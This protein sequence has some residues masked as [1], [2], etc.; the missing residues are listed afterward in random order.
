M[1]TFSKLGQMGRLGNS[2]FQIAATIGQARKCKA[3][4]LLPK[5]GYSAS[6]KGPFS[7]GEVVRGW[8]S[9]PEPYF[10]Y[11]EMICLGDIDLQGYFQSVK[12]FA[13]CED[14]IREIFSPSK[15]VETYVSS[16][17]ATGSIP[18]ERIGVHIRRGDYL[19]LSDYHVNLS[20]EYYTEAIKT[21]DGPVYVFSDDI[22]WCKENFPAD[23]YSEGD[24]VQDLFLFASCPRKVMANSSLSWWAAY[25][26]GGEV[27]AP[28]QWFGP[29]LNH[30]TKDLYLPS[31]NLK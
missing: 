8:K 9:Y 2:M 16:H 22:S 23:Y 29:K 20:M 28:K 4:Y 19:N 25:L 21:W 10:H 24:P 27:I 12:Y 6:F 13:H 15:D 7:Q 30:N 5:W 11:Q 18:G 14:E 17:T 1:I 3:E 26:G 31:W